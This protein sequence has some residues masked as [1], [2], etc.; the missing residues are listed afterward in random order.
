MVDNII[1]KKTQE[2]LFNQKV[3]CN[4]CHEIP[5][6]KEIICSGGL[7]YFISAEC[8]NKHGVFFCPIQ[9]F[10]QEA[11]QFEKLK[12]SKCEKYQGIVKTKT[13]LFQF[14]EECKFLC[15]SCIKSKH[16]KFKKKHPL[17]E[18][19]NLDYKCREH[20]MDYTCFCGECNINFC[21]MCISTHRSHKDKH[22]LKNM[23]PN[24]KKIKEIG[25][26]IEEQKKNVEE[27]NKCL[28]EILKVVNKKINEFKNNLNNDLKLNLQIYNCF[29]EDQN[30]YQ[31]ILNFDKIIDIDFSDI[32]WIGEINNELD[33]LIK[34]IKEKSP[35]KNFKENISTTSNFI[36]KDLMDKFQKTMS[37][38]KNKTSIE[39]LENRN[40]YDDFTNNE[41][42]KE[43]GERNK[44]LY[45]KD[46]II[47]NLKDIYIL[48]KCKNYLMLL[49]NGIFLFSQQTNDLLCYIDINENLEYEEI[50]ILSYIY[51]SN[52]SEILLF[53]GINGK[54]KI[55]CI[56]EQEEY[57]YN[58]LQEIRLENYNNFCLND[59]LQF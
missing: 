8:L 4:L 18:L 15:P 19:Q 23:M 51:V 57:N 43:I 12:C 42:L 47:G 50:N 45:K 52:L 16:K 53:I 11:N 6:I 17:I 54:I 38:D 10:C 7:S 32:S 56:N 58:L 35:N 46:E 31:S 39:E 33:K 2:L 14:C 37:A 28:D 13:E 40:R 27:I 48:T 3:R 34:I 24:N 9:D 49:D 29:S 21:D 55:Y 59:N 22:T 25:K 44:K 36:D 1:D 20:L 5:I 41:L 30:N 26:K